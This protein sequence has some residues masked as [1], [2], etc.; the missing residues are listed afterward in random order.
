LKNLQVTVSGL[1]LFDDN[2]AVDTASI[3]LS[4]QLNQPGKLPSAH[5]GF[6]AKVGPLGRSVPLANAQARMIGLKLKTL[7]A[8]LPPAMRT[9]LGG[10]GIDSGMALA[11]NDGRISL[12]A[13]ALTD[14]NVRYDTIHG[15]G[16][17]NAP[18]IEIAPVLSGVFRVK[19]GVLNI[20]KSGLGA[21]ISIAESSVDVAKEVGSGTVKM[22]KKLI[23]G[24]FDTGKGIATLD[25]K[26]VEKGIIG[27]TAGTIDLS[28]ESMKGAGGA[29]GGG[30]GKSVSDLTGSAA[31]KARD[32]G[33]PTRYQNTMQQ[34]QKAL[35]KMPYPPVTD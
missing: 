21:G 13:L 6:L 5:L 26:E 17:L 3:S 35:E 7:G 14:R 4:F 33:I 10:D 34:A 27:S 31:V 23:G 18:K 2:T 12:D 25:A 19:I 24:L 8:L 22:G 28:V 29:A 11:L 20:G 30:L 15:R 9:A 32:K 1:R 16:P